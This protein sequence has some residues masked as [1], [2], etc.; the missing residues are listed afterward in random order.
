M[1]RRHHAGLDAPQIE[2]PAGLR[3]ARQVAVTLRDTA[4]DGGLFSVWK[5][6][7]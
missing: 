3:L 6:T 7:Q 1:L 2:R 4:S 5:I